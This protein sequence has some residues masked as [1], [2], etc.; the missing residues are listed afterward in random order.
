[1]SIL[2]AVRVELQS[3]LDTETKQKL[4]EQ[5]K[6]TPGVLSASFNLARENMIVT[7]DGQLGTRAAISAMP[8]VKKLHHML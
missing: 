5:I 4:H 8:G 1:M 2:P 7:Y 3:G 6:K